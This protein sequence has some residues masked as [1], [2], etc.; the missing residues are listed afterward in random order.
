[1]KLPGSLK[2]TRQNARLVLR[3]LFMYPGAWV[4]RRLHPRLKVVAVTGSAGKTTTK[5]L[6]DAVFSCFAPTVSNLRSQNYR[7][8]VAET[9]L[10]AGRE[11]GYCVLEM[12]ESKPGALDLPIRLARPDVAI[13][14]LI[15]RDHYSAFKSQ[16]GIAAE[17][18]K[19]VHRL[20]SKG[21]AVLNRDD[22]AIR[23]IGESCQCPVFWVGR[24]AGATVR[25]LETESRWPEPL[26]LKLRYREQDYVVNTQLH[27]E[28]LALSVLCALAA[29]IALDVSLDDA[30]AAVQGLAPVE[31][32]MQVVEQ[33]GVFFVRDDW[34]AP[35]WSL[36]LPFRFMAEAKAG[37]KI[38]V[39]GSV[40]DSKLSP[41]KRYPRIASQVRKFAD[42]VIFIGR[43][44]DKALKARES[45]DDEFIQVFEGL[46]EASSYLNGTL[47]PGDL[48]LLKGTN[49][50]DH[51]VRLVHDYK[52]P[53]S[54]WRED[55]GR[56]EF[57]DYCE[58]LYEPPLGKPREDG[59]I[60]AIDNGDEERQ[61]WKPS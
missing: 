52:S 28:H 42:E 50:Q 30:I 45:P 48:V 20:P 38:V 35:H 26:R 8:S 32:R 10:K 23:K 33:R 36:D 54:C 19:L 11:H 7:I 57:C 34:K 21:I 47:K 18:A 41:S 40:S 49:L 53:I 31:G 5:D 59:A 17:M 55:C 22:P 24:D 27:G 58:K 56:L 3:R 12:S 13:L 43:Y 29:A 6:C 2:E 51:L 14:T 60:T 44:A 61:R 46:A 16:E 37:R 1:M 9:L 4:H 15:G 39:V 25:L